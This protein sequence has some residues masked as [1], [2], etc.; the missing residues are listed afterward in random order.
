M[1]DNLKRK[2]SLS[3]EN[4]QQRID[5]LMETLKIDKK[6]KIDAYIDYFQNELERSFESKMLRNSIVNLL[7]RLS[8]QTNKPYTFNRG[9]F[10]HILD[11][12]NF[13]KDSPIYIK[14]FFKIYFQIYENLKLNRESISIEC[15]KIKSELQE[16]KQK[17]HSLKI[18]TS[19]QAD[20]NLIQQRINELESNI[21]ESEILLEVVDKSLI[22][23][24]KPFPALFKPRNEVTQ[25]GNENKDN[26][27]NR[28]TQIKPERK[29]SFFNKIAGNYLLI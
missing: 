13:N 14:D 1:N 26:R 24:E 8:S 15:F 16:M 20:L 29:D 3:E 22:I 6:V 10:M 11:I 4:Y 25:G 19:N 2:V 9:L 17:L 21:M 27:Q 18:D 7:D 12:G 28:E 5:I 23:L